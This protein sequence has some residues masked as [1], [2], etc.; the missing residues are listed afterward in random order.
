MRVT[1]STIKT[2]APTRRTA[3]ACLARRLAALTALATACVALAPG[4]AA[5]QQT[6]VWLCK[7]GL[8][9]NPCGPS[10]ATT[11]LSNDGQ[12]VLDRYTPPKLRHP[13]IDCFYVYPTVSDDQTDNSDLSIDP[14]ER[15]IALYQAARYSQRCRVF[16]PMYRQITL[17]RLLQG[18][19][20]I[21]PKMQRI[22]YQSALAGWKDYLE[23]FNHGRPFVLIGHSQG[24]FILRQLIANQIDSNANLRHRLVSAILLGGNVLVK[25]HRA[26][27]GDFEHISA[28]RSNTQLHCVI[29]FST[30]NEPVPQDA[31]FGRVTGPLGG[32]PDPTLKVL[33]AYPG[34]SHL[35]TIIPTQPFAP[36]T[37]IGAATRLV[38]FAQPNATTAWAEFDHAYRGGCSSAGGANV[39]QIADNPNAPHLRAIPDATWGL[40]LTDANIALGNLV[41]I[42]KREREAYFQKANRP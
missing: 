10:L 16:A 12:S 11:K 39:L 29:A 13:A 25:K 4:A 32:P 34:D 31:V 30:F 7:P 38:G 9:D 42:V 14:E 22:A 3:V 1:R 19:D 8:Q 37:T 35:K 21:T 17:R 5:A 20:T 40:H 23:N 18:R 26:T 28:C 27:G 33:C 2:G 41:H 36:N 6:T 24:S 15:S